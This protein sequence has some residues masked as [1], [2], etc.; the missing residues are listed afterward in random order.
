M[1]FV[2]KYVESEALLKFS[3]I[4]N[5]FVS[6][7]MMLIVFAKK[8]KMLIVY[9]PFSLQVSFLLFFFFHQ[10]NR[11][12]KRKIKLLLLFTTNETDSS[13]A[14]ARRSAQETVAGQALSNAVF[15]SSTTPKPLT[16]LLLGGASFSLS[17]VA[18]SFNKIDASQPCNK[19]DML[20]HNLKLEAH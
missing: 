14:T 10:S 1:K 15:M 4:T 12:N 7:K 19:V 11:V 2:V 18:E 17:M 3:Y 13:A 5:T 6:N 8:K 9:I 20:L 16:E